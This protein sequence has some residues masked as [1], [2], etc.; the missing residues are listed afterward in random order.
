MSRL[1]N[2]YNKEIISKLMSKLSVKN[3]HDV[4]KLIKVILINWI[5]DNYELI[6]ILFFIN[7]KQMREGIT[8]NV[9]KIKKIP[10]SPFSQSTRAPADDAKVVRPAVPRDANNAY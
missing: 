10:Q 6:L 9:V 8:I 5:N 2:T 1:K 7:H 4:P 3:K